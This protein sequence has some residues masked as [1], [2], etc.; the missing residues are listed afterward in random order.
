[1]ISIF[2]GPS[3]FLFQDFSGAEGAIQFLHVTGCT[4][5]C[6]DM[7]QM[8]THD[9]PLQSLPLDGHTSV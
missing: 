9:N 6:T 5:S 4:F 3:R 7:L 2:A 8:A 1:M